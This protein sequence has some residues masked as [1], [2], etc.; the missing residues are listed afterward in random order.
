MYLLFVSYAKSFQ[1][2]FEVNEI[3]NVLSSTN[4]RWLPPELGCINLNIDASVTGN[5]GKVED[6]GV[7]R[8]N[9]EY[10]NTSF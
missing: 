6:G 4:V 2:S 7:I 3:T 9:M 8:D 10:W 5:I 1:A